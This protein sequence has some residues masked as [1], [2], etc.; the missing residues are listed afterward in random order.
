M[1]F[2]KY[3]DVSLFVNTCMYFLKY[4]ANTPKG[5]ENTA[6][7][8]RV[9]LALEIFAFFMLTSCFC[10]NLDSYLDLMAGVSCKTHTE[11]TKKISK[12]GSVL[13][14]KGAVATITY[15]NSTSN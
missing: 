6:A 10:V 15:S 14:K 8:A 12:R 3:I 4:M 11:K 13:K 5:Q 7:A 1:Y 9:H 2:L